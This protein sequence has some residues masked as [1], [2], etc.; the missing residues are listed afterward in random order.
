MHETPASCNLLSVKSLHFLV[1]F[2]YLIGF[3]KLKKKMWSRKLEGM[4]LKIERVR[5]C[6]SILVS[7]LS[8][9]ITRDTILLYFENV[10][11]S[12][13]GDV[14]DVSLCKHKDNTYCAV[15]TFVNQEGNYMETV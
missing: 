2:V 11:R 4:K 3:Q 5:A 6:D 8:P 12:G 1:F 10:R 9:N 7:G 14:S 15:V 13:G